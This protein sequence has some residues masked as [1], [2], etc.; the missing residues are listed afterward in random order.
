[1]DIHVFGDMVKDTFLRLASGDERQNILFV[2]WQHRDL[3]LF[4]AFA[5]AYMHHQ[6]TL[7]VVVDIR[8]RKSC[9]FRAAQ[10]TS[11]LESDKGLP[12]GGLKVAVVRCWTARAGDRGA[13][14]PG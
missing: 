2:A 14:A 8:N 10:A 11:T 3:A 5:I 4:A 13:G 9:Q 7:V 6:L 1:M 12:V